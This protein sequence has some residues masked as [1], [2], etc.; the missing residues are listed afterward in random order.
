MV[1]GG[2]GTFA[3]GS[4]IGSGVACPKCHVADEVIVE[5][6]WIVCC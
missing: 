6:G 1:V 3:I 4:G 2:D 5:V